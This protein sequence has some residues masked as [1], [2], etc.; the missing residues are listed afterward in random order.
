MYG[1]SCRGSFYEEFLFQHFKQQLKE[2]QELQRFNNCAYG[3]I[4]KSVVIKYNQL[5]SKV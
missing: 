4:G 5:L 2:P 3:F 1:S